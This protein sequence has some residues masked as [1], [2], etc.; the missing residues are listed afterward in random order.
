[1]IELSFIMQLIEWRFYG[2]SIIVILFIRPMSLNYIIKLEWIKSIILNPYYP[3]KCI[4][5]FDTTFEIISA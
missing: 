1:M 3:T 2:F 5:I 4:M